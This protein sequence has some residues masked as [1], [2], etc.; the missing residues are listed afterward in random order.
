MKDLR[1]TSTNVTGTYPLVVAKNSST[2]S[3]TDGTPYVADYITPLWVFLQSCMDRVGAAMSGTVEAYTAV[4]TGSAAGLGQ[5]VGDGAQQFLSV[6][7]RNFGAP[8]ELVFDV[9]NGT[10]ASRRVVP[11]QGTVLDGYLYPDLVYNTWVGAGLNGSATAFYTTSDSGGTTRSATGLTI[12]GVTSGRY[13]VT[14]DYRGLSPVGLGTNAKTAI[15]YS[16]GS[17]LNAYVA[18]MMQGHWHI[19]SVGANGVVADTNSATDYRN[20]QTATGVGIGKSVSSGTK[21][22]SINGAITDG[23]NGT[24]RTGLWTQTPAFACRI[25]IRY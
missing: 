16:G 21:S 4:G 13:L 11:L 1:V 25:G 2:G 24:P 23:T 6:V 19:E 14:P 7:A 9:V 8:G 10:A 12:N 20:G 5:T 17:V 3:S 18:D 22:N 15:A